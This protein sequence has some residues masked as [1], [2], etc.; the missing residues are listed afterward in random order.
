MKLLRYGEIGREKPGIW[1]D[2][3]IRDLSGKISDLDESWISPAGLAKLARIDAMTLPIV[4]NSP[5]LGVPFQGMTKFVG[6]GLNFADHAVEAGMDIPKEP[7]VFMKAL[8]CLS[9]PSDDIVLPYGSVKTD[10]EVEL[11]VVIGRVSSHISSKQA[12][13]NIAG[14]CV[15]NDLSERDFQFNRGGTWDKGKSC[16]TFGPVGPWLVTA[17]E[18]IDPQSLAMWLDVNGDRKQSGNT[19]TMIMKILDIVSYLSGFMTLNPG[20]IIATG[21]PPGVGMGQKPV[22]M[23]LRAGDVVELGIEG[24]GVQ[25]QRVVD[26]PPAVRH[27]YG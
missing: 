6:I 14:F 9:G 25:R 26:L 21:T 22:P 24:L 19:K 20:D 15:V 2:G 12:R 10:Y 5:R 18:V 23:Y 13:E 8:S 7:P 27:V 17:D 4:G 16:D 11:G 1:F 3:A